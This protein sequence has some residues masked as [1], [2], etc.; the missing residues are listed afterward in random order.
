LD[1]LFELELDE[2]FEL[3][4]DELLELEL[5]ELL[6]ANSRGWGSTVLPTSAAVGAAVLGVSRMLRMPPASW[7]VTVACAA[8]VAPVIAASASVSAVPILCLFLIR[9]LLFDGPLSA[10]SRWSPPATII[11]TTEHRNSPFE[12]NAL[13]EF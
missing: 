9:Y 10:A 1:E 5:D 2:L 11:E 7:G 12:F 13:T 3:E 6:P 4:L 8:P